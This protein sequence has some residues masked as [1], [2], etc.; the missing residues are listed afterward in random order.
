MIKNLMGPNEVEEDQLQELWEK[1]KDDDTGHPEWDSRLVRD[2]VFTIRRHKE[3]EQ[4]IAARFVEQLANFSADM[5]G[6]F[7][8][9]GINPKEG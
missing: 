1:S 3:R 4:A 9:A 5:I 2:L 6:A 8:L 7:T